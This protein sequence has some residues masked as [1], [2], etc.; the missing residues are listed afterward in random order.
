MAR[1][2]DL[3]GTESVRA[4]IHNK[5]VRTCIFVFLGWL[6]AVG[7]TAGLLRAADWAQYRGPDHDGRSAEI[8]RTNWSGEAP[9]EVW[10]VPMD[11]GLSSFSVSGG[12]VF[13]LV[14]RSAAGQA[15]EFCVALDAATG[16]EM[17]ASPAL[18]QASYP[19]GGVGSDDGPRS[20]PSVLGD[21][22]YV[23]TSYLRLYC[24]NA[25]NGAVV[26]NHDL[27]TEYGSAVVPWQSAASPLIEGDLVFAIGNAAGKS[28]LAFHAADGSEAWK[29]QSDVMTQAS[30][31]AATVAG[32][33]QVIY[34][35]RS[36]LVSVAPDSGSVL[37]RYPFPF[38]TSTGASP[39]VGDDIVYCSAAYGVGAGAVQIAAS[40]AGQTATQIWRT[41]G[42]NMNHWPTPVAEAGYLYGVYGQEGVAASL[43]CV[44]LA[45]GTERWRQLIGGMGGTLFTTG[46]VLL[47]TE[48]GQLV[49]V[50][51]DP[52][53]YNEVARYRAL[54]GSKSS[55]QGLPVKCWNVP[56]ISGG[57]IYVRSTTEAVCLDVATAAPAIPALRLL[58]TIDAGSGMFRLI[59]GT[60]DGSALDTNRAARIGIFAA[61]DLGA[62]AGGWTQRLDSAVFS[63]GQVVLDDPASTGFAHRF[64]RVE[65]GP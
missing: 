6:S 26:W 33:R 25:T 57:R 34:F 30:P 5:V 62:G 42:A 8:I 19:N 63:N 9:L 17:W 50:R 18:G 40:G 1:R 39:V 21:R 56:A 7:G 45:T 27:V 58:S 15:Q 10:K 47:L 51:P 55:I 53:A 61:G 28:L 16:A 4:G 22:V 52:V 37:W 24:L 29:G 38:S 44:D 49:L 54:D 64:F 2:E 48:D 46:C 31:V 11:P 13:T 59:V 36:G 60:E 35:A 41:V 43:R 65:E 12:R 3:T 32:V 20:T 14:R 23:M